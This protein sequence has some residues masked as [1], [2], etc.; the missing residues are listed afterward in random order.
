[1]TDL[2]GLDVHLVY[3][4]GPKL[5][6]LE[7]ALLSS[8]QSGAFLGDA[9]HSKFDFT[10]TPRCSH[11]DADDTVLHWLVCPRYHN[12]RA[13]IAD[14]VSDHPQDTMALKAHLLPSQSPFWTG[15]KR[16]LLGLSDLTTQYWS[17]PSAG[18]NHVFTD[19]AAGQS[20]TPYDLAAWACV[21]ATTGEVISAGPVLG[22]RQTNDRAELFAVSCCVAMAD[23]L[24]GGRRIVD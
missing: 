15:W 9:M 21:N 16:A 12:Q 24:S 11:C 20:G 10:K 4:H 22:L 7:A 18:I 5:N 1:M 14:W 6:A 13:T 8:L 2:K 23:L 3:R 17:R 19:G